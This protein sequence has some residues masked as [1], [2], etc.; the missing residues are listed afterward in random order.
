MHIW[1]T[2]V[3]IYTKYEVS[4]AN[5]VT[6]V[7]TDNNANTTNADKANP[8]AQSMIVASYFHNFHIHVHTIHSYIP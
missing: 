6:E 7:C 2:Y 4:A 8:N 3:H 1:G 5:P